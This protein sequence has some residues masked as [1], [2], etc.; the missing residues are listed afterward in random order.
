MKKRGRA[1]PASREVFPL[2]LPGRPVE[3]FSGETLAAIAARA[4]FRGP[5]VAY[6]NGRPR[7]RKN[8]GWAKR[9]R[10]RDRLLFRELPA[11]GGGGKSLLRIALNIAIV[12]TAG[13]AL[14]PAGLGLTGLAFSG[15][16][17]GV[18][19]G[20]SLLL[21]ALLPMPG[22]QGSGF[23]GAD[24][25]SP[26]YSLS[27]AQNRARLG[28]V[29]A[30]LYGRHILVPDLDAAP[31]TEFSGND[32]YLMQVL[33]C[34]LGDYQVEKLLLADTDLWT[35]SAGD[36][37]A[38]EGVTL[39]F[40][41]PGTPVT[42][43][44]TQVVTAAEVTGQELTG[45]NED[46]AAEAGGAWSGWFVANAPGTEAN[47]L[48]FDFEWRGGAGRLTDA[49]GIAA[50][51]TRLRMEAQ[52]IDAAGDPAGDA[53][54]LKEET[55]SF[56]TWT[57]QRISER[58]AV[59]AGRWRVRAR[60][61][62]DAGHVADNRV[63]DT[64]NWTGLRAYLKGAP[65]SLDCY[66]IAVRMKAG[67]QLSGLSARLFKTIQTAKLP[68]FLGYDE[69]GA[70]LWSAPQATRKISAAAG[71]L[72]RNDEYG[73]E[74]PD[75]RLDLDRLAA[76]DATW[77]ARGD[78]FD[79]V[80][81]RRTT[82]WAGLADILR[83]GRAEPQMLG[84]VV[85]FV[86]DEPRETVRAL[87]GPQNIA[88]GSFNLD[89]VFADEDTPDDVIVRFFD[90]ATWKPA[91]AR[92]Q[93]GGGAGTK[94]ALL[95]YFGIVDYEQAW[96]EAAYQAAA[97]R[98]RRVFPGFA[99][100]LEG[101]LI[102]RGDAVLVAHPLPQWG[103]AI[104]VEG[105]FAASRLL[106]LD[107]APVLAEAGNWLYLRR[108][109]AR[110]WGPARVTAGPGPRQLVIDEDDLAALGDPSAFISTGGD[111]DRTMAVVGHAPASGEAGNQGAA[112]RAIVV[113]MLGGGGDRVQLALVNDDPAVY[114]ADEGEAPPRETAAPVPLVPAKPALGPIVLS[115]NLG[116][117]YAPRLA[118]SVLPA[119]GAVNYVWEISYDNVSWE[120]LKEGS[121]ATQWQGDVETG[122]VWIAVTAFGQGGARTRQVAHR[123]LTVSEEVPGEVTAV[124]KTPFAQSAF[125]D[126]TL[127]KEADGRTEE[128][129][130]GVM[131]RYS[132]ASGF[133]P[134]D[135]GALGETVFTVRNEPATTRL[136]VP[137]IAAPT[138]VRV[139]AYNAFGE[140]GL[141]WSSE[142][143]VS[144]LALTAGDFSEA[145]QEALAN[146]EA[147]G[148]EYVVRIADNRVVGFALTGGATVD[149]G[150]LVD[151]LMIAHPSIDGG[152]P[153]PAFVVE[154]GVVTI[155]EAKI[156][157]LT[158]DKL[159][160][161]LA[162]FGTLTALKFHSPIGPG[163]T[164]D[165]AL[166]A[167]DL[168]APYI[169]M[170]LPS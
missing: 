167:I 50:V 147:V 153:F 125:V 115:Q 145:V 160:A 84:D 73:G 161:A 61:I 16:L 54:L 83:V 170:K 28:E 92:A 35:D 14:G 99:A 138:Y 111:R 86:R 122:L 130:R 21:N 126:F 79:G 134:E 82:L 149:L 89:Y 80:F 69:G 75:T 156:G 108:R 155:N 3:A 2:A 128:G 19:I 150:F 135:G 13:W 22:P 144:P 96:R 56:A 4:R 100:G 26:T 109:N 38:F 78:T 71:D 166:L 55:Y 30:R 9:L 121:N 120:T 17:A 152:T 95:D 98:R 33:N 127:P 18:H 154:G 159:A 90:E 102:A 47:Y 123:N 137:L 112:M 58:F 12:L 23:R 60:R 10:A 65:G 64:V 41:P 36:T 140:A 32:Q 94:P 43:F 62:D 34:G 119:A 57:A 52:P 42:L 27:T 103:G 37:G 53:V 76:L 87:F 51:E 118:A 85:T 77:E 110:P 5:V 66:R 25:P 148:A 93:A 11:G 162:E 136:L 131:A 81:D 68:V 168:E 31:Y 129:L 165:D 70:P 139:A 107:E 117:R 45:A 7:L 29:K 124:D 169:R 46:G 67:N 142:I 101:R 44:P 8:G 72:L 163:E 15:A 164:I 97:N 24:S 39:E 105:W 74:L 6:V 133:D 59:A 141:N 20:A 106:R 114:A 151:K 48:A 113:S 40:C 91:Q 146:A 143:S 158:A 1:I 88:A 49:G 132:A 63:R 116:T 157:V 104:E